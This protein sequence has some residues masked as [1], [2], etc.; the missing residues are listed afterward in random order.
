M[1]KGARV[2]MDERRP[3]LKS[4]ILI[5]DDE[6]RIRE[7]YRRLFRA[8]G[9]RIFDL[10]EAASAE[11]AVEILIRQDIDL[12]LLDIN[13]PEIN[14]CTLFDI[15]KEYNPHAEIIVAS[16]YPIDQQKRLIPFAKDYYDKS[17]G[18]LKLIEK[19]TTALVR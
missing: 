5:V 8:I 19:V 18:S 1:D 7:I 4:K 13:M 6:S 9:S 11:E 16:V 17:Q 10:I 14:G 3:S 15:I 2:P 12:I